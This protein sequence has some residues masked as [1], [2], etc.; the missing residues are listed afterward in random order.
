[1]NKPEKSTL[2]TSWPIGGISTS[3]TSDVTIFPNAAPM[4]TPTAKSMTLPR[5][6]NSLNSFSTD[7]LL[8]FIRSRHS[9]AQADSHSKVG[10]LFREL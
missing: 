8:Y 2:P 9:T 6:A 7:V 4:I 1:M 3:S 5:M 10:C